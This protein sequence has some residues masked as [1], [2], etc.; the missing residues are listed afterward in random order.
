MND[1]LQRRIE[2]LEAR[3]NRH[4]AI[5]RMAA[6]GC[7]AVATLAM[8]IG[9]TE[10]PTNTIRADTIEAK[11]FVVRAD[12]GSIRSEFMSTEMGSHF[13]M[14]DANSSKRIMLTASDMPMWAVIDENQQP[15]ILAAYE[16]KVTKFAI[17]DPGINERISLTSQD[18]GFTSM[19]IGNAESDSIFLAAMPSPRFRDEAGDPVSSTI[20]IS[21]PGRE[22]VLWSTP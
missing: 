7:I 1:D 10:A 8:S 16:P 20:M 17:M 13:S 14:F 11:R 15:R 18:T 9:L 19:K 21:G 12:D 3:L 5:H 2:H 6:L 4:A 22:A